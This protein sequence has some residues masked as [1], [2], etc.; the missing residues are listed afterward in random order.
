MQPSTPTVRF[1]RLY[2]A[3]KWT[4]VGTLAV[5]ALA[6]ATFWVMVLGG[7]AGSGF[8][9]RPQMS[10]GEDPVVTAEC[11]WPY[12]VNDA[13]AKAVCRTFYNLSPEERAQVLKARR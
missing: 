3:I 6:A 11:A 13:E 2:A 5:L 4:I 7:F 12:G 10:A 8:H 1:P 9:A